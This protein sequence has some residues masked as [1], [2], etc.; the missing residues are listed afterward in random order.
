ME[1]V[2]ESGTSP[3]RGAGSGDGGDELEA[4]IRRACREGDLE[5]AATLTVEAYGGEILAFLIARLRDRS[6]GEEVFSIFAEKLWVGLPGY[7]GRCSMRAW[8]YR[9][10]RN[11]A[12]DYATA[13][14]NR[15]GRHVT[16]SRHPSLSQLVERVRSATAMHQRTETK[17]RVRQLRESLAP[18]DQLLLILR[19]DRGMAWR[20]LAAA[21][22]DGRLEGAALEREAA[23]VRKRFERVKDQLRALAEREGL[24]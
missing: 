21:L 19:V 22:S 18:D 6:R 4:T 12:N 15:A 1:M 7:E 9:I 11:A 8:A 2:T 20:E 13:L 16:L 17:D 3:R 5:R 23:R 24:I 14:P 10:A